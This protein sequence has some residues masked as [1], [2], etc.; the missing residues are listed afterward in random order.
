MATIADGGVSSGIGSALVDFS[1]NGL[2]PEEDVSSLKLSPDQLPAAIE[3][4]DGART[5]LQADIHTI[6]QETAEDVSSWV[7]NAKSLQDDINRSKSLANDIL[8]QSEEPVVSGKSTKEA[9]DKV[10]FL[11]KELHY[12]QQVQEALKGIRRVNQIL[13]QVE[14]ARDERRILDALRLLEKS[15]TALDEIPVGKSCR[16]MKLLDLRAFELKSDVHDVFD[17]VWKSLVEVD[18]DK[19]QIS[20]SETR[21]GEAM[22]LSDAV[23]GLKAYKEVDE[24]MVQL[25]HDI[26]RAVIGPRTTIGS[27]NL[28]GIQVIDGILLVTGTVDNS[29]KSLFTDLQQIFAFF[30]DHLP[31]DLVDSMSA[32]MMPELMTRIINVWLDSAV[33]PSLKEMDAFEEVIAAAK[34]FCSKLENLRFSG[35]NELQEWVENAP[36]VWLSKCRETA[37]D[38]V[39]TRL[40]GGLGAPK[41]VERVEKQMVS[42]SEG[43]ELAATG[44]TADDN[45]DWAA[46]DDDGDQQPTESGIPSYRDPQKSTGPAEDDGTD[47]W[48]WG[49]DDD[50]QVAPSTKEVESK[51][52]EEDDAGEDAWGWGD[53][54]PK[55]TEPE[56]T[57]PTV[58]SSA[59]ATQQTREM[60]LKETYNISS[61]PEP[62]LQLIFAILEDGAT[63]TQSGFLYNDATYL[64][65]KLADFAIAWKTREDIT[66]R[67]QNMLRLDNDVKTL[68]NFAARAYG[69]EMNIQKT[70]LR[71]LLGGEQSLLHQDDPENY[72]EAAVSRIRSMAVTWEVILAR[73][74]WY[75]AVGSLVEALSS[76]IIT[77]VMDASSISQ[78]QA[79]NVAKLI[80]HVAELDD[81]FLPSRVSGQGQ[82]DEVPMTAQYAGSWLR[83]KYLSEVLQS[84]LRDIRYLWMESE[85]SLY[86]TKDEVVDLINLSFEDNP[87][88]REVIKEI[89]QNPH[90]SQDQGQV[91]RW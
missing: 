84:N 17:H 82:P 1:V 80:A 47:A 67:A 58:K 37:L 7:S 77:D 10:A 71:D 35:F 20:I 59:P 4:V 54:E 9:E 74:A 83:L 65:E 2:F 32:V 33:P 36:R 3:A 45:Q 49:E 22:S 50:T 41:Q 69:N 40:S 43:K 34:E 57:G 24:R 78:D 75:Q 48:G 60:T 63:L 26:D 88:T 44:T 68:Q 90:P 66:S 29:I 87:R 85:L 62:V 76:K 70:V 28:P 61:M 39:R 56:S 14:Q 11:K 13:D 21:D 6:N 53:E 8:R 64:A 30:A 89:T 31:T 55:E 46:W 81:L 25:W 52:A 86:F 5:K 79:Y 18:V 73:S 19:Q 51:P 91:E 42:R 38:A 72:V 16:V 23:I 27:E 12:N 15:W